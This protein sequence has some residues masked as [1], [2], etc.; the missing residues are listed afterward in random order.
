MGQGMGL[1]SWIAIG[2]VAG[3]LGKF[4]TPGKDPGG[5]I[6]TPLIGIVG[7]VVGGFIATSLGYGGISGFD[8]RSL[9]IATLGAVLFL[10]VLRLLR[11]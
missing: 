11:R 5:C 9:T 10:L 2:L 4:L 7:A 6:V 8:L 1:L 3:L